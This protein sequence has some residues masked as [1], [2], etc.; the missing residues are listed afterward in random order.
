MFMLIRDREAIYT[1]KWG[2]HH[3]KCEHA[4]STTE[5]RD[6]AG[7]QK[8]TKLCSTQLASTGVAKSR[9]YSSDLY[10]YFDDAANS[11]A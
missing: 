2:S 8:I 10:S 5:R 3:E 9:E 6:L 4:L 11:L 7:A 1:R